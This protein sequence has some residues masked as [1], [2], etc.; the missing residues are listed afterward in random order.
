MSIDWITLVVMSERT[1]KIAKRGDDAEFR[2]I[3]DTYLGNTSHVNNWDLV[4]ISCGPIVGVTCSIATDH[5]FMSWL[6][7]NSCGTAESPWSA[8]NGS[9][10]AAK[11]PIFT[12]WL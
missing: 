10:A 12:A 1:K 9:C 11:H 6:D 2:L 7:R 4:D 5:R 3:Y 8:V